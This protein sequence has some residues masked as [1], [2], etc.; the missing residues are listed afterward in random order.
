MSSIHAT[1]PD[2]EAQLILHTWRKLFENNYSQELD[3][4]SLY[5]QEVFGFEVRWE[6]LKDTPLHSLFPNDPRKAL[7]LGNQVI[8]E[9]FQNRN[10]IRILIILYIGS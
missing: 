3:R 5:E 2:P 7:E 10:S 1:E 9:Q 8:R 6:L 4:S